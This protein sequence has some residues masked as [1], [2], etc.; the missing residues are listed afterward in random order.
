MFP[1]QGFNMGY[2]PMQMFQQQFGNPQQQQMMMLQQRFQQIDLDRS[3]TIGVGEVQ[4]AFSSPGQPFSVESSKM[5]I[6]IFDKDNQGVISFDEFVALDQFVTKIRT[7]YRQFDPSGAGMQMNLLPQALQMMGFQVTPQTC[8]NLARVYAKSQLNL[9]DY[10]SF[11]DISILSCLMRT[12][13]MR[14]AQGNG[15]CVMNYDDLMAVALY[16][17]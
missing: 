6:R 10:N 15:Q 17:K 11:V 9:I 14:F 2:N 16:L 3:G 1:Q 12:L 13:F 5:L 7:V 4:Q 8:M